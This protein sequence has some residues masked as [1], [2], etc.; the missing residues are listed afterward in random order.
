MQVVAIIKGV[1]QPDRESLNTSLLIFSGQGRRWKNRL[2]YYQSYIY[3][4]CIVLID[5]FPILKGIHSTHFFN[6]KITD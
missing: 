1:L 4:I 3:S 5:N 6:K 2:F